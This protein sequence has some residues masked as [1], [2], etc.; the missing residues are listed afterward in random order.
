MSAL[1]V[2]DDDDLCTSLKRL[3]VECGLDLR[4]VHDTNEARV[5]LQTAKPRL[6]IADY[7]LPGVDT[8]LAFLTALKTE[9]PSVT[10]VLISGSLDVVDARR[11]H[12]GRGVDLVLSKS[13]GVLMARTVLA[14]IRRVAALDRSAP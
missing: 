8:G 1:L 14:E 9:D 6:V 5:A 3:V 4:I 12:T 11:D 2:E 13:D 10:T 7:D